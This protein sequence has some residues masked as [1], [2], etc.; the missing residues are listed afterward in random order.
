MHIFNPLTLV[1]IHSLLSVVALV[2]GIPVVLA[3]LRGEDRPGWTGI[4]LATAVATNLTGF[5]LPAPGFLPSHA[6]GILSS[7]VLAASLVARYRFQLAGSWRRIDAV[8]LILAE[9]FLVFVSIAQAFL[10]VPALA[11]LVV[12]SQGPFAVVQL[13]NLIG[14]AILG[15]LV[16]R[17]RSVSAA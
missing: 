3:L 17:S 8:S 2:A 15:W 13:V 7:A 1:G 12:S 11:E 10:K 14:F 16:W 4:F 5:I 9:Y 6:V